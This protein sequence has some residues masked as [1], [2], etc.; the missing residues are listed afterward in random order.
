[1]PECAAVRGRRVPAARSPVY[2]SRKRKRAQGF[3]PPRPKK[4][5]NGGVFPQNFR[6]GGKKFVYRGKI[7]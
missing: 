2:Y 5:E 6:S 4:T 3:S 1:M 7:G